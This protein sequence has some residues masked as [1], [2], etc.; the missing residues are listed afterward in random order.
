MDRFWRGRIQNLD[1]EMEV[2]D[3]LSLEGGEN[4]DE[5]PDTLE[6]PVIM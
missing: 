2:Y 1:K 6:V 4:T 5:I 3:L